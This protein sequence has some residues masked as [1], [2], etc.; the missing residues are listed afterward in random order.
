MDKRLVRV[1]DGT[2]EA[3]EGV[4]NR[5]MFLVVVGVRLVGAILSIVLCSLLAIGRPGFLIRGRGERR[6]TARL[7]KVSD[8]WANRSYQKVRSV[9]PFP[10][11]PPCTVLDITLVFFVLPELDVS[12]EGGRI[13]V[14]HAPGFGGDGLWFILHEFSDCGDDFTSK[15]DVSS[16]EHS[17]DFFTAFQQGSK[18]RCP[19]NDGNPFHGGDTPVLSGGLGSVPIFR[20]ARHEIWVNNFV[21]WNS[22]ESV[23]EVGKP[24][25]NETRLGGGINADS[26]SSD[27]SSEVVLEVLLELLFVPHVTGDIGHHDGSIA[28][29]LV[30]IIYAHHRFNGRLEGVLWVGVPILSLGPSGPV[31]GCG[32]E[33]SSSH[34]HDANRYP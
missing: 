33:A 11:L 10:F 28:E 9:F 13:T 18:L 23:P 16:F 6:E 3:K 17:Q 4:P 7:G 29:T 31:F 8:K 24:S 20:R 15:S 32:K 19:S 25:V 22:P 14:T 21:R 2:R 34:P 12:Q 5:L 27:L 1:E 26:R 30:L